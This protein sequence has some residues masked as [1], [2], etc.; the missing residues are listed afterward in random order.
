MAYATKCK[1]GHP[2]CN[3]WHVVPH[4][5]LQGNRFTQE[6][7]EAVAELLNNMD[8]HPST[9][10]KKLSSFMH[11]HPNWSF[12]IRDG[13]TTSQVMCHIMDAQ[14]LDG[15]GTRGG[16]HSI[17]WGNTANEAFTNALKGMVP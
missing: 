1:C 12:I 5:A 14:W 10:D 17:A 7:A 3:A 15:Y 9:L 8:G 4:A 16:H 6:E 13:A 11:N 2:T